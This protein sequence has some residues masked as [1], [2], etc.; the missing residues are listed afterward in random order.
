MGRLRP[1]ASRI[2]ML[3]ALG[4]GVVTTLALRDHIEGLERRAGALGPGTPMVVAAVEVARGDTFVPG[5]V[6]VRRIPEEF[7]P[8]GALTS[9][10]E[11]LGRVAASDVVAGEAITA[12]RLAPPGG[13]IAS[14]VPPGLRA[15]AVTVASPPG[16]LATGDRVD[17]LATYAAG[18]PYTET[19]V[20]AAEV[21]QVLEATA[22][23][24]G[25]ATALLLLV[26]PETAERIAY[27]RAFADLSVAIAPAGS[28]DAG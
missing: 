22:V 26:T 6:S 23:E 5:T 21:L 19:V 20:E 18:R 25:T 13:P 10:S 9:S 1:R 2:L 7:V 14:L 17:V 4:L 16:S 11:A 27:A 3:L 28:L 15:V 12:S 24:H 8:P